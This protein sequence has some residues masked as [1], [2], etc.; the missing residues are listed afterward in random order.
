[1]GIA[2]LVPLANS[3]IYLPQGL[4]RLVLK[5]RH[6][7]ENLWRPVKSD[8]IK[9]YK[10]L[11]HFHILIPLENSLLQAFFRLQIGVDAS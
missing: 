2:F 1:M 8:L 11:S 4:T 5:L 6:E 10:Q 9:P 7:M 3:S